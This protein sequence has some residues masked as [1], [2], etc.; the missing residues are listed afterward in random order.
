MYQTGQADSG[1]FRSGHNKSLL[2]AEIIIFLAGMAVF[3]GFIHRDG[4][5]FYIALAG[6]FFSGLIIL[7]T[8]FRAPSVPSVLGL[9]RFNNKSPA[10]TWILA[11]LITGLAAATAYRLYARWPL[12]PGTLTF[13][14]FVSP[15]IGMTEELVFRGYL[16][17]RA[18]SFGPCVA[19]FIAAVAHTFYKYL[20]LKSLAPDTGID[21]NR[22]VIFTF[23][24]GL[25]AASLREFSWNVLPAVLA[26]AVFDILVYGDFPEM[27]VWVWG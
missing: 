14:A 3:A 23:V 6:L 16:Q 20:V 21:F 13:I 19:V 2:I 4:L 7:I 12:L 5:R 18:R 1:M 9:S 26:H 15:L 17:G 27:P 22:L 24:F 11:G 8:V 25:I 10:W